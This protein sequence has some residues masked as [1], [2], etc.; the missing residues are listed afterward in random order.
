MLAIYYFLI[1]LINYLVIRQRLKYTTGYFGEFLKNRLQKD[2][3]ITNNI[4]INNSNTQYLHITIEIIM[5]IIWRK[6]MEYAWSFHCT[7]VPC[8]N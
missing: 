1:V 5:T 6:K 4:S 3:F 7:I 8:Y 2:R